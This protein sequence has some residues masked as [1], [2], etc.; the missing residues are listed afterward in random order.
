MEKHTLKIYDT[1]ATIYEIPFTELNDGLVKVEGIPSIDK[2]EHI[3]F[4]RE[5]KEVKTRKF[6]SYVGH[7]F[8]PTTHSVVLA[9]NV[10]Q[11]QMANILIAI[12][13]VDGIAYEMDINEISVIEVKPVPE[14]VLVEDVVAEEVEEQPKK[15]NKK[16][17]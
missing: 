4:G 6:G 9:E 16:R 5:Y 15:K 8:A 13:M 10:D 7:G 2:A 14:E 11:K 3:L 1:E 17:K 12:G